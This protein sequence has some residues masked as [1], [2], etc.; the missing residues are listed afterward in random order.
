MA[1]ATATATAGAM[2]VAT[3]PSQQQ[4]AVDKSSNNWHNHQPHQPFLLY[5]N[6]TNRFIMIVSNDSVS[7]TT[8]DGKI[9]YPGMKVYVIKPNSKEK[10]SVATIYRVLRDNSSSFYYPDYFCVLEEERFCNAEGNWVDG[11][12]EHVSRVYVDYE[13]AMESVRIREKD[14][15]EILNMI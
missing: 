3:A 2:A 9:I 8:A 7:P 15:E 5:T 10:L 4:P 11:N 14:F 12:T 13:R 1:T 6:T